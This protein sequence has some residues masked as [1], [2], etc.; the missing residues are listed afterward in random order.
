MRLLA[1][2]RSDTQIVQQVAAQ[3]PG[4]QNVLYL[5]TV[6]G[7]AQRLSYA[8]LVKDRN[9]FMA[10]KRPHKGNLFSRA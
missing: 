8:R 3:F 4:R 9:I 5:Y 10:H 2:A 6:P 7:L 1:V